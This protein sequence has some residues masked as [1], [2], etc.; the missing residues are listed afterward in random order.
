M[1]SGLAI[2]E[3][4]QRLKKEEKFTADVVEK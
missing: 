2:R 1:A 3:I 4:D